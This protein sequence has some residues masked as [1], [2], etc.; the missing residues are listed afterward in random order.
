MLHNYLKMLFDFLKNKK[1]D[2]FVNLYE[3]LCLTRDLL[4]NS[5]AIIIDKME[6][7]MILG[8]ILVFL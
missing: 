5:K 7:R 3:S 6:T 1:L 2:S 8:K 4:G